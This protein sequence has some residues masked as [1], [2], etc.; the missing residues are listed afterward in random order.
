MIS[1]S[2]CF[3]LFCFWFFTKI[4]NVLNIAESIH[5]CKTH[6]IFFFMFRINY[7]N[8]TWC[9]NCHLTKVMFSMEPI[10]PDVLRRICVGVF[11]LIL[12]N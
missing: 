11:R 10:K 7:V 12:K 2:F 8:V 1:R 3:S 5:S 6:T 9:N 4:H